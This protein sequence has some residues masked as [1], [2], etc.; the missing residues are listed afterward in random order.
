MKDSTHKDSSMRINELSNKL[1]KLYMGK[2]IM[3]AQ[4]VYRYSV[5]ISSLNYTC[6]KL[7]ARVYLRFSTKLYCFYEIHIYT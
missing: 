3:M 4:K 2:Y 1:L 5:D 7:I 6:R